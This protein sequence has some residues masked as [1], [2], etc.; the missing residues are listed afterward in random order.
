ML[1]VYEVDETEMDVRIVNSIEE[2]YGLGVPEQTPSPFYRR[3]WLRG[4]EAAGLG[5]ARAFYFCVDEE[6]TC[7]RDAHEP[8]LA[9]LSKCDPREGEGRC[10]DC[11][12]RGDEGNWS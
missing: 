7:H 10:F 1:L 9:L 3:E 8:C 6:S 11:G 2:A 12:A 4:Y 5:G